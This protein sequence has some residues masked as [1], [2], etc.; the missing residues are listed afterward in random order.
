ML[1]IMFKK[2]NLKKIFFVVLIQ[3]FISNIA[4]SEIIN[5]I[6]VKGNDRV[7]TETVKMFS[8]LEMGENF[9][10]QILNKVL[11]QLY[12][13]NYFSDVKI[14]TKDGIIFITVIENPIIQSIT[15]NGIKKD[16]ILESLNKITSKMEKYPF[17]EN[18]INDQSILIKNILKSYG[19]YFV[20]LET[21]ISTNKN[22]TVDL[23]YNVNLGEV[24]KIKKIKFI[25]DKVFRDSVL[26]NI[27][28]S[29]ES[30]FWKFLSKNK[31]LDSNRT[32]LDVARLT[33][34]YKN[35]GYFNA[36]VKS[37]NAVLTNENQFELIFNINA[38][39]K[40]IINKI[41][42]K[43]DNNNLLE[44]IKV[45]ESKSKDLEGKI[46]S[47]KKLDNLIKNLNYFTL[48]ND[49]IF[50]NANFKE[51]TKNDNELDIIIN[52]DDLDKEYVKKINIF[53]NY[54][55]DEK[56][57]RNQLIIDEGDPFNKILFNRSIQDIK[58]LNI[59][60]SVNYS[61]VDNN[62]PIK[63][64]IFK[65]K[66]QQV[67]LLVRVWNY[68]IITAGIKEN[69]YLGLGIQLDTNFLPSDDS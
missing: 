57:L 53:G 44:S 66:K 20:N 10:N 50:I 1:K 38:G 26:R 24:A 54:I 68:F 60:K 43:G 45:F 40:F 34:Y 8:N 48:Q 36:N 18:K 31:Y 21:V 69:N 6:V 64:L 55:T 49:F 25:G 23:I 16:N 47:K 42:F 56:V 17:V 65:L 27:I 52:F 13:T 3:L 22:N 7:S 62:D 9:N 28:L 67:K 12:A 59:F 33:N 39:N 15:I 46:Y 41:L 58:S 11:K 63:L 51:I 32:N 14:S 29:E 61:I 30:K 2:C 37:T 5:S 19:Y 35:K 4:F